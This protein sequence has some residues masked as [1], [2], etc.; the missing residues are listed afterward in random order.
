MTG[1][2]DGAPDSGM[3]SGSDAGEPGERLGSGELT[4]DERR[5]LEEFA[6]GVPVGDAGRVA[7]DAVVR[8]AEDERPLPA[9]GGDQGD[10]LSA[11]FS[12]P[13]GGG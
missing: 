13:P 3:A 6:H 12:Q 8:A 7:D 1:P 11:R 4:A 10:G 5:V 2:D 9:E